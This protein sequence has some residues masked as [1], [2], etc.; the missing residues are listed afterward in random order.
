MGQRDEI[1]D[2]SGLENKENTADGAHEDIH[3]PLVA[4]G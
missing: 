2:Q 1:K 4:L 3:T